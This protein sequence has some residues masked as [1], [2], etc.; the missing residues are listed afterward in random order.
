M[1]TKHYKI[2]IP[3]I[4]SS[5]YLVF[6][7]HSFEKITGIQED[8]DC[9]GVV[10]E[11]ESNIPVMLICKADPNTIA[12]ESVHMALIMMNYTGLAFPTYDD[13]E[14]MAYMVGYI[15]E[16]VTKRSKSYKKLKKDS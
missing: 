7:K 8:R 12:H 11:S 10:A 14:L 6:D 2:E 3:L 1:K 13:Q 16:Q 15:V 9:L 5:F 4:E